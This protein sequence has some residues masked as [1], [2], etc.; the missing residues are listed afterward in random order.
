VI[1]TGIRATHAEFKGR[2]GNGFTAVSDGQGTS[3]C[4]GT[5]RTSPARSAA[6]PTASRSR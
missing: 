3:D 4:N 1:D 6:R 2:I 5:A